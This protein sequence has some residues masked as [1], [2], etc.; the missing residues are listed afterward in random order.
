MEMPDDPDAIALLERLRPDGTEFDPDSAAGRAS[1]ER[2]LAAPPA[3]RP[4]RQRR[5]RFAVV[6]LAAAAAL[7]VVV[8][9][10]F[11]RGGSDDVIARAAAA[12]NDPGTILHLEAEVRIRTPDDAT[13][14][15]DQPVDVRMEVWQ[16]AGARQRRIRFQ[17]AGE[18]VEDWD[19]KIAAIYDPR[20]DELV[21]ITDRTYFDRGRRGPADDDS[22]R[23]GAGN[24]TDDLARLLDRA[25]SGEE[26]LRL[27]GET[28][29]RGNPVHEL[30]IEHPTVDMF[31]VVY[32]DRETFLPVRIVEGGPGDHVNLITD[33]PVAERLPRTPETERLLRM[34]PHPGA[35]VIV[36][37]DII[38]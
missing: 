7:A 22:F 16:T 20:Q 6:G 37:T 8:L 32:V 34:S 9:V 19:A 35:E 13:R 33:F 12:L 21:R 5:R 15:A 25:R 38:P 28:D 17:D 31:R 27:A 18:L 2:I 23:W 3:P 30:R 24:V 36:E 4:R 10:P 26:N 11:V 1:L 14:A 29:V